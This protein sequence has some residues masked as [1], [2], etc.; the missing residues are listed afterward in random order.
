MKNLILT[1]LCGVFFSVSSIDA[2][3]FKCD[4]GNDSLSIG[5][6]MCVD[7]IDNQ[8]LQFIVTTSFGI[9]AGTKFQNIP[10]GSFIKCQN[11]SEFT[12]ITE[13]EW[14][15]VALDT[16]VFQIKSDGCEDIDDLGITLV[17]T[18]SCETTF[19]NVVLSPSDSIEISDPCN[20]ND[21][22]NILDMEGNISLFR[23]VL[24]INYAG[25]D[26]VLSLATGHT[27][28]QD[29]TGTPIMDNTIIP[30]T[31]PG[32]FELEFYRPPGTNFTITI[33]REFPDT[34]VD[35]V[36]FSSENVC[37]NEDCIP[38]PIPDMDAWALIILGVL[39]SI[40]ALV[41]IRQRNGLPV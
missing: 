21:P 5:P 30:Q 32:V 12:G 38:P 20:C 15:F 18:G 22:D 34:A 35:A 29:E 1:L 6:V 9:L 41:G 8:Y 11:H 19:E 27:N 31:A 10:S 28:F 7:S 36:V 39:L 2:Q 4:S 16:C 26:D 37:N 3:V 40:F 33:Q 23:D 24:T 25:F 17:V 13:S 14:S